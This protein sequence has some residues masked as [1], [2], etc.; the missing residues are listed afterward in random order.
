M[1]PKEILDQARK[2][3]AE[4]SSGD[5]DKWWYAN[6]YVF[7]RLQL[8]ERQTKTAV[9][10]R[11][12]DAGATCHVCATA[13]D[14]TRGVHLHRLDADR[15][16]S[17][18]NCVLMHPECHQ[19]H[20]AQHSR[21]QLP[22]TCQALCVKESKRYEDK[23]FFYWWDISPNEAERLDR[24]EAVAFVQKDTGYR[25]VLPTPTL[26]LLLTPQRQ[27]TR[28]AGNWGI[29]VLKNRPNQLAFEPGRGGEAWL[30][31]PVVWATEEQPH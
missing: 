12:L 21:E 9:K 31:L 20:H 8:D 3:I 14:S 29:K 27:T 28:G 19:K 18:A 11:L 25:C 16:Y 4:Y 6:R 5:P 2:L 22:G 30:F 26:K 7:A 15:G 17:E 13:F 24:H 10:R 1:K 23:P